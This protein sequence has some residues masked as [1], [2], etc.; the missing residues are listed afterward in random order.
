MPNRDLDQSDVE[1]DARDM[2]DAQLSADYDRMTYNFT[3]T[4]LLEHRYWIS[5]DA[6]RG[7]PYE[8]LEIGMVNAIL[9]ERHSTLVEDQPWDDGSWYADALNREAEEASLGRP[10]FPNEY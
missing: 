2:L 1:A 8:R 7:S 9:T 4:E 6:R 5:I 10:L 3:D